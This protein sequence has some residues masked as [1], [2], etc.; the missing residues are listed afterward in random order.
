MMSGPKTREEWQE[1]VNDFSP[2][3]QSKKD[4]ICIMVKTPES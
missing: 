2:E 3:K 4:R 1:L